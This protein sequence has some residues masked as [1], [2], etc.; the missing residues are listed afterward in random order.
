MTNPVDCQIVIDEYEKSLKRAL[1]GETHEVISSYCEAT[2]QYL[3][4]KAQSWYEFARIIRNTVSHKDGGTLQRWPD[5]RVKIAKWRIGTLDP[6][7]V[8]QAIDFTPYEALQLAKDHT[9]FASGNQL[10]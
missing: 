4:Y 6:S 2:Y 7:M 3:I 5:K 9:D 8:G 10:K 1:L